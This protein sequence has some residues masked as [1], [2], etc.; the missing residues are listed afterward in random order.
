MSRQTITGL[1]IYDGS[2]VVIL[3][4]HAELGKSLVVIEG[5]AQ[6]VPTVSLVLIST[7]QASP[8]WGN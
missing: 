4:L 1:G 3:D 6:L 8:A 7:M 2:E 5:Q